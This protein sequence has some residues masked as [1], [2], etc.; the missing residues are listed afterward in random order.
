MASFTHNG[1]EIHFDT[2]GEGPA[3][4]FM[5]G[6]TA[7]RSQA[8]QCL[9]GLAGYRVITLDMPGHGESRLTPNLALEKQASFASY[10]GVAKALLAHLGITRVIAG[11]I[12]M[13]AG[14]ALHLALYSPGL[15]SALLLVRPAW[16]NQPGRP[17]LNIIEDVGQAIVDNGADGGEARLLDHPFY[18]AAKTE[19]P[20]CAASIKGA[21]HRPQA[22]EAAGVLSALV[23]DQPFAQMSQLGKCTVPALVVGNNADPLHPALIARD[24]SGALGNAEYFHAPPKYLEPE[25][26]KAAIKLRIQQFLET[27]LQVPRAT[28]HSSAGG[29]KP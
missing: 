29:D 21:I 9:D 3:L 19:N 24:I 27:H 12:S 6:L 20:D 5:H 26:H 13:G 17:H 14:L 7:D 16:L 28:A 2:A 23:A 22:V 18:A 4:L 1:G 15:V 11:G 25:A 10:A 8:Q